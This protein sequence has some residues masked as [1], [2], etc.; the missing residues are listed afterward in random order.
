MYGRSD[1]DR[2]HGVLGVGAGGIG[3]AVCSVGHQ[4]RYD[5]FGCVIE[6]LAACHPAFYRVG[7]QAVTGEIRPPLVFHP[8]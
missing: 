3:V 7:G 2:E 8:I 6:D 1:G 4:H 5:D